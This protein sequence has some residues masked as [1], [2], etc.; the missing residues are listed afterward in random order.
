MIWNYP[1]LPPF[2]DTSMWISSNIKAHG[3]PLE[4]LVV[5]IATRRCFMK[6]LAL[7]VKP[8]L[9]Q[10]GVVQQGMDLHPLVM[11]LECCGQT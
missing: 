3:P 4:A 11:V 7:S 9:P 2:L 1:I 5:S 10:M 8:V 6:V